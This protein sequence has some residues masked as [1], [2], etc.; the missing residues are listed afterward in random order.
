MCLHASRD[1]PLQHYVSAPLSPI[2]L[3][4]IFR[5]F[6]CTNSDSIIF[7]GG[8]RQSDQPPASGSCAV[9]R[10]ILVIYDRPFA[11]KTA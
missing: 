3:F 4:D 8:P 6:P 11:G 7:G 2:G 9:E 10:P 1:L 5:R